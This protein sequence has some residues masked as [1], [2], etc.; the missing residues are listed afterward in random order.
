MVAL[1]KIES[2]EKLRIKIGI[3]YIPIG[4]SYRAQFFKQIEG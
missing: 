3:H 4:E 1:S 2:I